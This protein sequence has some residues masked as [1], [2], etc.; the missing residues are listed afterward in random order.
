MKIKSYFHGTNLILFA[1][2]TGITP[3]TANAIN[4]HIQTDGTLSGISEVNIN[5]IGNSQIYTLSEINGKLS[6]QNLFFSFSDFS[7][8]STDTAKFALNTPSLTNVISRVTGGSESLISGKL[9]LTNP[10]SAPAFYFI[11][12][13]G[14]TFGAGASV[15]VPGSFY[16][17]TAS[18][19]NFSNDDHF[20]AIA[21][22]SSSLSSATPESFGFLGN[23]AGI[24]NIGSSETDRTTLTF[25]PG[26]DV[27]FSANHIVV[28]NA[29]VINKAVVDKDTSAPGI[30][31]QITATGS[32]PANIKPNV[33]ADQLPA[34]EMII[35]NAHIE[36]SGNGSGYLAIQSGNL[37][38]SYSNLFADNTGITPMSKE[39][40]GVDV[41]IR[42]NLTVGHAV[43]SSDANPGDAGS[44]NVI[45]DSIKILNGGSISS[46]TYSSGNSGDL[47]IRAREMQIDGTGIFHYTD[48]T[49]E[50][51]RSGIFSSSNEET[52]GNAGSITVE[53]KELLQLDNFGVIESDSSGGGVAG[54]VNV[55]SGKLTVS[56]NAYISSDALS[57]G[58]A[59]N[60]FVDANSIELRNGGLISSSTYGNGNAGT[61]AVLANKVDIDGFYSYSDAD[62]NPQF[63]RSG[64]QSDAKNAD[65]GD[66]GTVYVVGLGSDIEQ[67]NYTNVETLNITNGGAISTSSINSS[68]A[69]LAGQITVAADSL[70]IIHTGLIDSS[71]SGSGNAGIVFMQAGDLKIDGAGSSSFTGIRSDAEIGSSGH[72]GGVLV[73][74]NSVELLN[75]GLIN[76]ST[77]GLGDAGIVSVQAGHLK[78]DGAGSSL[79]TGIASDTEDGSSGHAL[80]VL[81]AANSVELLNGGL[82]SSST[83]GIGNAGAVSIEAVDSIELLNGGTISSTSSGSGNAGYVLV[84]A[85]YLTIDGTGNTSFTGIATDAKDGNKKDED[86]AVILVEADSIKL[87]NGGAISSTTFG[88]GKAG[89][90]SI[91]AKQL[92]IDGTGNLL[93]TGIA[94]NAQGGDNSGDAF[95]IRVESKAVDLLN[96]GVISSSTFGHGDA[97][98]VDIITQELSIDGAENSSFTGIATNAAL[99]LEGNQLTTSGSAGRV[100]IATEILNIRN[101][102]SI[103]SL[104]NNSNSDK[105]LNGVLVIA[106]QI[107]LENNSVISSATYGLGDA[108]TMLIQARDISIE[109][110]SSIDSSSRNSSTGNAG[111]ILVVGKESD[112]QNG[113]FTNVDFIKLQNGSTIETSSL[114]NSSAGNIL[115]YFQEISLDSEA[116]VESK[117][118]NGQGG[119][120]LLSGGKIAY[121][122]NSIIATSA[123]NGDGGNIYVD[124]VDYL[125]MQ[126]GFI[127]SNTEGS[128]KAGMIEIDNKTTIIA[129]NETLITS[130]KNIV[131]FGTGRNGRTINVIQTAAPNGLSGNTSFSLPQLNLNAMMVNLPIEKF[132]SRILSQD[133]CAAEEGSS[134]V[135]SGRGGVRSRS[136]DTLH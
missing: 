119:T 21:T 121:L 74:A 132:D 75:A 115:I 78:I 32:E 133:M 66:A 47:D 52:N 7:I 14:I 83:K 55:L 10:G 87:L 93:F 31:L 58:S 91:Q 100:S 96:G 79:F 112:V 65:S 128:G 35:Q 49:E 95:G 70:N 67:E 86:V 99:D 29:T 36:A 61:V 19:L 33:F 120:I 129:S 116:R 109:N 107:N 34:G 114:G 131:D 122:N 125:A 13:A 2:L 41:F 60:V 97:G 43:I 72:A 110:N 16:V 38:A 26:T 15:D 44:V 89:L 101:G 82:I 81:V 25:K 85:R 118:Q 23:E 111:D 135:V 11:N 130:E 54:N 92:K 84:E 77:S 45:A 69:A 50:T 90:V 62:G 22:S 94:S 3:V 46:S 117:A 73:A 98:T 42:S 106:D 53:I 6:G 1:A 5:A 12:P 134:L 9:A 24:I 20:S 48:G 136:D 40:D 4:T 124:G 56:N 104:T 63:T 51:K 108:G 57:N 17:S 71:T 76:S 8:G 80:G 59:G 27:A 127:Q 123:I 88:S 39:N 68:S 64:I 126:G 102:G 105:I 103:L 30:Q 28:D 18:G 113:E 37:I